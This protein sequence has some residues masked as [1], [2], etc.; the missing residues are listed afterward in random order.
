MTVYLGDQIL[1]SVGVG[2]SKIAVASQ[3]YCGDFAVKRL[4]GS[5]ALKEL[6][7]E[8]PGRVESGSAVAPFSTAAACSHNTSIAAAS[9]SSAFD[10]PASRRQTR[11]D[12]K[13]SAHI[14]SPDLAGSGPLT[15]WGRV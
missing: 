12:A 7:P 3:R 8:P 2:A 11:S 6:N 1:G 15:D 5:T 10:R 9:C 14:A 4:R 13:S